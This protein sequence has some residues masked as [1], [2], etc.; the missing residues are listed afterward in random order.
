MNRLRKEEER[1]TPF[2]WG[3][4]GERETVSEGTSGVERLECERER[5]RV[6]MSPHFKD[7]PAGG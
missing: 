5:D 6:M 1:R 4:E 7:A 2:E 3:R